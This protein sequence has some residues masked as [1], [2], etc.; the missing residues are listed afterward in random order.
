MVNFLVL[1]LGVSLLLIGAAYGLHCWRD[2]KKRD[3]VDPR[4]DSHYHYK[5][6]NFYE[7][8]KGLNE[9]KSRSKRH[10]SKSKSESESRIEF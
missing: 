7:G 3:Y 6:T 10:R 2:K 4:S 8:R 5:R 9:R 1:M